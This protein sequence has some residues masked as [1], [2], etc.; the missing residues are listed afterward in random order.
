MDL[1]NLEEEFRKGVNMFILCNP[2]NPV[3]RAWTREE[4]KTLAELLVR[5]QVKVISDEIHSDLLLFGNTHIPLASLSPEVADLCFTCVAPS[6]T[7]NL[8][9][10]YTSAVITPNETLREGY[11]RI[12]DAVHVGGGSLFGQVAFE[13]AYLEGE[14]WLTQLLSYLE[15]NF[16]F[17]R[18]T[19]SRDCPQLKVTPLEATYLVWLDLGFLEKTDENLKRFMI[20][21][22]RLGL[23]E[24]TMFGP[25]G[26]GFQRMNIATPRQVLEEGLQQLTEALGRV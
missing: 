11:E 20:N 25:G 3:G 12:L 4:L 14:E 26:R 24:G 8:A 15:G 18:D 6:K 23:N 16:I 13:A 2:H 5:Y 21:E 1:E 22:A 9:G 10:L 19:L 17:L 7:F